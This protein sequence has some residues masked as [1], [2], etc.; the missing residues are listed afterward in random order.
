MQEQSNHLGL[1]HPIFQVLYHHTRNAAAN[2][3]DVHK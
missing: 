2:E 1:Q 3:S